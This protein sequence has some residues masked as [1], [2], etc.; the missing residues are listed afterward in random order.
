M[1]P[2]FSSFL[3]WK[4]YFEIVGKLSS[5]W[6]GRIYSGVLLLKWFIKWKQGRAHV[7]KI[8]NICYVWKHDVYCCSVIVSRRI[9]CE[10]TWFPVGRD[11][12]TIPDAS[13]AERL[14]INC[15][16]KTPPRKL[17]DFTYFEVFAVLRLG[18]NVCGLPEL[19]H[20]YYLFYVSGD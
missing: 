12:M 4:K 5:Q 14:C 17:S 19:F 20:T 15:A 11:K 16:C 3:K 8:Y 7:K 18:S 1:F 10:A 9:K 13:R 2:P 6:G